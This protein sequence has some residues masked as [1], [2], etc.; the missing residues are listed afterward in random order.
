M[1][2]K[3]AFSILLTRS[4][5][6][7][8]FVNRLLLF[9]PAVFLV[10]LFCF[11]VFTA[12]YGFDITDASYHL[13][14]ASHPE[15]VQASATQFGY[16]TKLLYALSGEDI[17]VFRILGLLLLLSVAGFFS[18]TLERYW[19]SLSGS[20]LNTRIK[21]EVIAFILLATLVYY[22]KW[23]LTPS[24]NWLALCSTLI[25]ASGLLRVAARSAKDLKQRRFDPSLLMDAF[26]VG[27]GGGLSFMAKPTTALVLAVTTLF[28]VA[29]HY[30]NLRYSWKPFLAF[31]VIVA[32]LLLLAHAFVFKGGIIPF[33]VELREGMKLGKIL[34]GGHS[35]GNVFFQA[36]DDVKQVP[37]RVF[38]VTSAGV[39]LSPFIIW[40]VRWN[41]GRGRATIALR[42]LSLFLILFLLSTCY[43]L[44]GNGHL[45]RMGMGFAGL[46][47]VLLLMSSVV[48]TL[49][50]W[51]RKEYVI[52]RIS[53]LRLAGLCFFLFMLTG[54]YA[55]GSN[56]G[57]IR[58]MSGAYVFFAAG[59]LYTAFWIDQYVDRAIL[60]NIVPALVAVSVLFILIGAFNHP[61]R[62]PRKISEQNVEVT[63]LAGR[64][65]LYVDIPTARYINA[66]KSVALESGWAPGT[67]LIDLTGGS[68]GATVILGGKIVGTPWLFGRYKGSNEFAKTVLGMVPKSELQSA[69]VLTAPRGKRKISS[70]IM[71]NLGL[72]FPSD[73]VAVGKTKTGHREE[74]QILWKPL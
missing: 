53:F 33:Y 54:A 41:K 61:F 18:I 66:L 43:Q 47:L 1:S 3:S 42:I 55:F 59:A 45:S 48:V 23:L 6:V 13:L 67:P 39:L 62:L 12:S 27:I 28:W 14:W 5:A 22:G 7:C 25:V 21:W 73:Y 71:F 11:F 70:E 52:G 29:A 50:A 17:A 51:N 68:P 9:V 31:A 38:A 49:L 30:K 37:G 35:I 63:F 15:Q 16:Y 19:M 4:S 74:I 65:S 60:G 46:T 32:S 20:V 24:Y 8:S 10:F 2:N 40:V 57:L 64:G 72:D 26:L 36:V 44:W 34:G 58:Q 56:N 69:W